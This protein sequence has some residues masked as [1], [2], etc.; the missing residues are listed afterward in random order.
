MSTVN[1]SSV[2]VNENNAAN[3]TV[4]VL[5]AT[6]AD[7]SITVANAGFE[8]PDQGSGY[9]YSPGGASWAFTGVAGNGGGLQGNGSGFA[10]PGAVDGDQ[11]AF[12][13]NQGTMSQSFSLNA[14]DY[15]LGLS[16]AG[17]AGYSGAN[18]VVVLLDGVEV[19]SFTP[20]VNVYGQVT[21]DFSVATSGTHTFQFVGQASTGDHTTFIDGVSLTGTSSTF[22]LVAGAGDADNAAFTVVGDE[23]RLNAS[24]DYEG[25][26]SYSIRLQATDLAGG[27]YEVQKTI[28]INDL[29]E[30][31]VIS[32][33]GAGVSAS[34]S[35]DEN[36]V[37]VTTV[38]ASDEDAGASLTYSIS[39]G[40]D[41]G[42]FVIGA[43]TGALTFDVAP[44]YENPSDVGADNLYHVT[45]QVS[46][47]ALV[48][49]QAI[50]VT[51]AGVNDAPTLM[52]GTASAALIEAG[53]VANGTAGTG[54]SS[55][56]FTKSDV[57]GTVGY[58]TAYLAS[59]GWATTDAGV[60]YTQSGTYGTATFVVAT[61][62]V[63]YA[64]NNGDA[65]T[66]AL[67]QGQVVTETFT[68]RVVDDGGATQTANAVFSLTGSNDAPTISTSVATATL[69]EAGGVANGTAGTNASSVT[70]TKGDVDGTASY[71]ATYLT[72]HGWAT[73]DAGTTYTQV[74][75]YGS[76]TLTTTTGVLSY[77]LDN[78]DADTQGLAAGQSAVDTF[79]IQVTDGAATQTASASFDITGSNDAPEI[80]VA[81]GGT[82]LF[83]VEQYRGYS[84]NVYSSL[85]SYAASHTATQTVQASVIDYS[86]GG[87]AGNLGGSSPAW[88]DSPYNDNF[89][90]R[91]TA[92]L[93]VT[94][95]DTYTFRTINDDGVF[96]LI[97]G[98]LIIN[99]TGYHGQGAYYGNVT[100]TPGTHTL[101][102]YFFEGGGGAQLELAVKSSTGTYTLL[103]DASA[104][105]QLS[106]GDSDAAN[107]TETHAALASSGTVTIND[108]DLSDSVTASVSGLVVSG[109]GTVPTGLTQADL[110]AMLT[111]SPTSALNANPGDENNLTWSF[112]TGS[113]TFDSL[114][115]GETVVL[116][117]TISATDGTAT[118]TQVVTV[119]LTGTNDTP[120]ISAG[121]ASAA[122]VEAGGVANGTVGTNASSIALTI[123]DVDGVASYDTA[124]LTSNGWTAN[125]N[126]TYSKTG[127]Y[128][129]ATLTTATGVVSY[130]LD[131]SDTQTQALTAGQSTS[132]TFTIRVTDGS[133]TQ[134]TN[135]VFS[136]TGRNDTPT[137]TASASTA[138]LVEAGGV[139]NATVGTASANVT[140]TKGD[141]DGTA[142]Y[143]ATYFTS[144]G[145]TNNGNGTY[146]QTTTYGTLTLTTSTGA[147]S[148]VL[149]NA[150]R[151]TDSLDAGQVVSETYTFQVV[152]GNGATQSTDVTF[153]LTG[154]NDAPRVINANADQLAT[155]NNEFTY[156]WATTTFDVVD[157]S[158]SLSYSIT[159][160]DG[161]ALPEWL[162]YDAATRTFT[163]TPS[164]QQEGT[165][166]LRITATDTYGASVY[167]DF[168]LTVQLD[169]AITHGSNGD[170]TLVAPYRN[171]SQI[172]DGSLGNDTLLGNGGSDTYLFY[173][174]SGQDTINDYDAV[175]GN[176]DTLRMIDGVVA[177]DLSFWRDQ[178]NLYVRID[179][180]GDLVTVVNH[181]YNLGL[182]EIEQIEFED[183]STIDL[184][185]IN[186]DF[187][188]TTAANTFVGTDAAN[189]M[190]GMVGDD[191]LYG[192]LGNDTLTGGTGD[193]VL[194]GQ[195]GN[196]TYVFNLGDG[197]DTLKDNTGVNVIA[198]GA[199]IATGG[200]VLTRDGADLILSVSGTT[201]SLTLL[202]GYNS[203]HFTLVF[204]DGTTWS[205][206]DIGTALTGQTPA[207]A[208][209]TTTYG[210]SG[211]DLIW[212]LASDET[213]DAGLGNDSIYGQLGNDTYLFYAGSGQDF[214]FDQDGTADNLDT[215]RLAT[216][217][218]ASGVTLQ[219]VG[220]NLLIG[221][222]GS[223]DVLTVVNHFL[224]PLVSAVEQLQLGDGTLIDLT[225]LSIPDTAATL[226]DIQSGAAAGSATGNVGTSG[227]DQI[228]GGNTGET[229]NAG[230]GN[231]ELHGNG[232][233]DIY[234]FGTGSGHD[235]VVDYDSTAGNTDVIRFSAGLGSD[236]ITLQLD[237]QNLVIALVG[238]DDSI[239]VVNQYYNHGL[240]AIEKLEFSDGAQIDLASL[241]PGSTASTLDILLGGGGASGGG[242][243]PGSSGADD[244]YG[245]NS[246]DTYDTGAGDDRVQGNGGNDTYVFGTGYGDDTV[247]DYDTTV[248]NT[249]VIRLGAGLDFSNVTLRS[250]SQNLY[251]ELIGSDD[252]L[253]VVNQ[254]YNHG[255]YQVEQLQFADGSVVDLTQLEVNASATLVADLV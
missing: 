137:V 170:N 37:V 34:V 70:L 6:D 42:L 61:G 141:V 219:R 72:T 173:K 47:G 209:G 161:S 172:F 9:A 118:D 52:A 199:G 85:S 215:I 49:T 189:V 128:G 56:A 91:V 103:G 138:A 212:G 153:T 104:A 69:V 182:Y 254:Y 11:S 35:I 218:T 148:Y 1:L 90:V 216:G 76:V 16:A 97:D 232:G 239:T 163:G 84:T 194:E 213:F 223:T 28:T 241:D 220:D 127:V 197:Q 198:F 145:W 124:Y 175:A 191:S 229:F 203:T 51:V 234:V 144:H 159:L 139:N 50:A 110:L 244:I 87:N 187:I 162:A 25:Q 109:T 89:F 126:G 119:T 135:A 31:P 12:V 75:T 65:D 201:D 206:D 250:D 63:S 152:D 193:D 36:T 82:G 151:D 236:D 78:S 21:I 17:R 23:L 211:D 224:N 98:N 217:V 204:A 5:S 166:T 123:A 149:N 121:A 142:S 53:G 100:L 214:V 165:L 156:T 60:T 117:Y 228:D 160:A 115:A 86:D 8:T 238:S 251:V 171:T 205:A 190:Y 180:T 40:E 19:G 253:T 39:G 196:D 140:L 227:D 164:M 67:T 59:S 30:A 158:D 14:G 225:L 200:I 73:A 147:V 66:E 3:A 143:D 92:D 112:S 247:I 20:Q 33:N 176:V 167:D 48:D 41:A 27:T 155:E 230:A 208:T 233:N 7:V 255:I 94:T 111:V 2:S 68:L 178:M 15:T 125:G 101:E 105:I 146:S 131:D 226:A 136:I 154:S 26:S 102:L 77:T 99:D 221:L 45:V 242:G 174:G 18:P 10:A 222:V 13:Q 64:L 177:G 74:G 58:D 29:N 95:A 237:G 54:A 181:Y 150:D 134:T 129:T 116:T 79:T 24:A 83:T 231:D 120:T 62:V 96:L 168:T 32:S 106:T 240:Y 71:D 80:T 88:P 248:G 38:A 107:L 43:N 188:G 249:D 130:A 93:N 114:A 245:G 55:I 157:A 4:A 57:D 183:G 122:L 252:S 210:T 44:D 185:G 195:A 246:G 22:A 108:A 186:V 46:D 132:E 81:A 235:R 243:T 202:D 192:G 113:A 207:G 133:A 169:P 184:R 179:A